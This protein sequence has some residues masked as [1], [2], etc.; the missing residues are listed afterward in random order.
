VEFPI[1]F[2]KI[3]VSSLPAF[4]FTLC[5]KIFMCLLW[6]WTDTHSCFS[7]SS[8]LYTS[9]YLQLGHEHLN[10]ITPTTYIAITNILY[11]L[12]CWSDFLV[13]IPMKSVLASIEIH[14]VM[15]TSS[16]MQFHIY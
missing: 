6:K 12:N 5:N 9:F 15:F 8:H 13:Q 3:P 7:K 11:R 16:K 1:I 10:T 4:V 2:L 14:Y